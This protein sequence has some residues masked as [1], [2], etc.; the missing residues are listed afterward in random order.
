MIPMLPLISRHPNLCIV[1][2]R[3]STEVHMPDRLRRSRI[4]R[5]ERIHT[6]VHRRHIDDIMRT[7]AD[8]HIRNIQR[9]AVELVVDS[10][11]EEHPK[12]PAIHIRG[13][14]HGL[15]QIRSRSRT[16]VVLRQNTHLPSRRSS[17][18][19]HHRAQA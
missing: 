17:T 6:V 5:I 10:A 16:I 19:R 7:P 4:V 3:R 11:L 9:L 2:I 1:K 13:S 18:K 8:L 15:T 14:Q 12:L